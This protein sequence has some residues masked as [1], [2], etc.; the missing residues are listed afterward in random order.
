MLKV[1]TCQSRAEFG[2]LRPFLC[3]WYVEERVSDECSD[4]AVWWYR[5]RD[6]LKVMA[7]WYIYIYMYV[8]IYITVGFPPFAA[9]LG[10]G[11]NE[12]WM[13]HIW[14]KSTR[15]EKSTGAILGDAAVV[16]RVVVLS[17]RFTGD[18]RN[19]E[20]GSGIPS[21]KPLDPLAAGAS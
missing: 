10:R 5:I 1:V 2:W 3:G 14:W 19:T 13:R 18:A 11:E 7:L 6:L 4:V 15:R 20:V 16:L 21:G 8:Y 9:D 12:R 17:L